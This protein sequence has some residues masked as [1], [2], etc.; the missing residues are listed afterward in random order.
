MHW[1]LPPMQLAVAGQIRAQHPYLQM[2]RQALA[3]VAP[4]ALLPCKAAQQNPA[5]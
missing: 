3:K 5:G 2:I 1:A 4:V